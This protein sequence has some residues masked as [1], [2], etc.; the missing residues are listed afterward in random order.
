MRDL[1]G[2]IIDGAGWIGAVAVMVPYALGVYGRW[3]P[4]ELRYRVWNIV[5][6]V[7]LIVNAAYHHAYP[8]TAVNVVWTAIAVMSFFRAEKREG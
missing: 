8:S 3:R 4:T 1:V 6:A 2:P 5:G 7:L